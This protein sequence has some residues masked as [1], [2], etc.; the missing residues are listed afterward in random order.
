MKFPLLFKCKKKKKENHRIL[1]WVG[2]LV[3]IQSKVAS[4][5]EVWP[6]ASYLTPVRY[7]FP[8]VSPQAASG[9]GEVLA[10]CPRASLEAKACRG[11]PFHSFSP[12]AEGLTCAGPLWMWENQQSGQESLLSVDDSGLS[13]PTGGGGTCPKTPRGCLKPGTALNPIRTFFLYLH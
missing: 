10:L 5:R 4:C 7:G 12:L 13:L 1:K 8:R 2:A 6:G 3:G 11:Q 9:S